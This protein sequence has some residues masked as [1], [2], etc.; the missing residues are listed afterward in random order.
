MSA[1]GLALPLGAATGARAAV[2]SANRRFCSARWSAR[3]RSAQ[4]AS[5]ALP[6]AVR[7]RPS[8]TTARSTLCTT[9]T[10]SDAT[11]RE[12]VVSPMVG[13]GSELLMVTSHEELRRSERARHRVC[14]R[15]MLAG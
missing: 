1:D 2:S 7:T 15:K 12:M 5:Q 14:P 13:S 6:R 8:P 9:P 4:T 3:A 11:V 10:A